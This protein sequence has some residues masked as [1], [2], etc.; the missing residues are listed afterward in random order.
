MTATGGGV[1]ML[2]PNSER[3]LGLQRCGAGYDWISDVRFFYRPRNNHLP[4]LSA[5]LTV[6]SCSVISSNQNCSIMPE[7]GMHA[8]VKLPFS[9]LFSRLALFLQSSASRKEY[10]S[11]S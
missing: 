2:L 10:S 9:S 11:Y 6:S 3:G 5:S 7:S 1:L 8:L 4:L